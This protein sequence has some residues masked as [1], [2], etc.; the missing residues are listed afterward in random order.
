[1]KYLP[2][3]LLDLRILVS[4]GELIVYDRHSAPANVKMKSALVLKFLSLNE[5]TFYC[6]G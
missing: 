4:K 6:M 2:W 5:N 3:T 1:M